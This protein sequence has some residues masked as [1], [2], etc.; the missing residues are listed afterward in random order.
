MDDNEGD[1]FTGAINALTIEAMFA[2]VIFLGAAVWV[3]AG[4]IFAH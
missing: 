2:L 4:A 1:V 3:N